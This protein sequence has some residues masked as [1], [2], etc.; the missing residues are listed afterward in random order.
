MLRPGYLTLHIQTGQRRKGANALKLAW[1]LAIPQIIIV[2]CL[3]LISY[4]VIDSSFVRLREQHVRD[5]IENRFLFITNEIDIS[6]QKSVSETSVFIHLPAVMRAYEIAMSGD[7]D[8]PYSPETQAAREFLRKELALMLDSYT[9]VTGKRLQLHFHLPNGRSLVRLWRDK[10]TRIDGEWVDYSDDLVAIRPTIREVIK[11]GEPVLGLEPGSGGFAIRGVIPV[12][13]PDGRQIGSAE[14][15]QDFDPIIETATVEGKIYISLY[16]NIE[17]LD[18]SVELQDSEKY[19]PKGDFVRVVGAKDISVESL[20]TPELLARGKDGAY[21]EVHGSMTL[22]TFPLSD[23]N[24]KQV[25]VLICTMNTEEVSI[26]ANTAS[27][28]LALMLAGMAIA[29]TFALLLRLHRLAVRPLNM[30][31]SKIQDI[32]EDRADLSEHIPSYQKDEIGEL[33]RWFNTLTSKLDGILKDRQ[34]LLGQIRSESE[35]FESTAHW[36]RSILDAT[37]LPITVTDNDMNWTFVNKA[38]EDFLGTKLEDML[39]KPCSNWN[40]HICNTPNC[41]IACVKR[42]VKQTFFTQNERSHKVDVE[43]LKD[44][45]GEV[46]GFI[47]VVQDITQV[48]EMA[49]QEGEAKAASH[50]KSDF[51]ANM[52]HEMRTPMNAIIGMTAIGKSSNDLERAKYT[53]SKIEDASIHLLGIIND[54]LDMSKIEAG[55]FELSEEEFRFEKMLQR[56]VNVI[57]FRVDEKKQKLDLRVDKNLPDVLIGDDQ[58][59]AQVIANLMGNAV[60]F[61]PDEGSISLNASLAGEKDGFCEIQVE[62]IDSGIG[63]SREQ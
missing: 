49:K 33:A 27:I 9:E 34:M 25:G 6:S 54:I 20:I 15:L 57:S 44:L 38:V 53:L 2:A 59:L 22:T 60:K 40:A 45:N 36:Y 28:I 50:A 29:P 21:S 32:A 63:I 51:L 35:K 14:V 23:Y 56:V 18:F 31:K 46:S 17:L 61:T 24:G 16:A 8:D 42:G 7:M 26:L 10:N 30:I 5:V 62:V 13:T 12:K 43:I 41:G 48:E 1:K 55:K 52:S 19:P 47:E 11:S 39:G 4:L 37:P 58:R 3:G